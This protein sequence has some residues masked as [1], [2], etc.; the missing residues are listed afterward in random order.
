MGKSRDVARSHKKGSNSK[1]K[2]VMLG[3]SSK[4]FSRASSFLYY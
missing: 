4:G 3:D 1:G 2:C